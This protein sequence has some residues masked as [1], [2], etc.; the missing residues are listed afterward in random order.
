MPKPEFSEKLKNEPPD[1]KAFK[2]FTAFTKRIVQVS[3][4]DVEAVDKGDAR[5]AKPGRPASA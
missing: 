4:D 2:R 1:P 5:S 3:K